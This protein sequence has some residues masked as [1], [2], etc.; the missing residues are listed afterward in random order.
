MID[1]SSDFYN[2]AS[3]GT[4]VIAI[5]ENPRANTLEEIACELVHFLAD[6]SP[7]SLLCYVHSFF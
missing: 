2:F 3:L 5:I 7:Y 6:F 1:L 4:A